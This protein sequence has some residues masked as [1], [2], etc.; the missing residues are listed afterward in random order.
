MKH[1]DA[2]TLSP[3]EQKEK[4]RTALRMRQQGYRFKDIAAALDV[5]Q[6]T[7]QEW[8]S[9]Y[10]VDGEA[11][12]IAGGQRGARFGERRTLTPA[13]AA[14]VQDW[15]S[16]RQPDQLKLTFALWTREAVREL[17]RLKLGLEMPIRTVG[18][19][20]KRWGFTPQKPLTRAR[21]Q[22]PAAVERWL[23]QEYP[24]IVARAKAQN[25]EIFWGDETGVRNE[26]VHGRSFA[27]AGQT[28][29]VRTRTQRFGVNML[30]ALTTRGKVRFMLYRETFTATILLEFLARLLR[31]AQGR[32]VFL[33]LDNLRV[34]KSEAVQR[35]LGERTPRLELFYLPTYSP[36]LNPDEYLNGDL[37]QALRK[38]PPPENGKQLVSKVR[39]EMRRIQR[40]PQRVQKYFL[41]P[42]IAYAA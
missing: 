42:A 30:S 7:V 41:H 24:A 2:R 17:M 29:V 22:E 19:Y 38:R 13:Q 28:P 3:A 20:L 15:I 4:R 14:A 12:A 18:E 9:R 34:H 36:E 6:R 5:H 16:D 8:W 1:I 10:Q 25:A 26:A 39:S 31:E 23:R 11:P 33:I 27:P 32:K 37:K 40:R 21:E 35:W